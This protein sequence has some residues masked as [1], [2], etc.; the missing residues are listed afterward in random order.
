MNES[1]KSKIEVE[2][3]TGNPDY[4]VLYEKENGGKE[5]FLVDGSDSA[6]KAWDEAVEYIEKEESEPVVIIEFRRV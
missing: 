6:V 5:S 3:Q 2:S 4:F 1:S